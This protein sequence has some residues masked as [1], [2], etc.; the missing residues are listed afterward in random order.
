MIKALT[1]NA[2]TQRVAESDRNIGIERK[3]TA[4]INESRNN[5]D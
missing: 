4:L 3:K 5:K 2:A 1:S